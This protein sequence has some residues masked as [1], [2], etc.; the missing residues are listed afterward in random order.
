M[1]DIRYGR[2]NCETGVPPNSRRY[3]PVPKTVLCGTIT[4]QTYPEVIYRMTR[5]AV[6]DDAGIGGGTSNI[7]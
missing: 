5:P 4:V 7:V 2:C 1:S 6:D 3:H